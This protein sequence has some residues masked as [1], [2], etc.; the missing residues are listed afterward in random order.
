MVTQLGLSPTPPSSSRLVFVNGYHA[1]ARKNGIDIL[2]NHFRQS[3]NE[4]DWLGDGVYFWQD[5]PRRAWEW[6]LSGQKRQS[7]RTDEAAPV[8]DEPP[9]VIGARILLPLDNTLDLL[10]TKWHRELT[11]RYLA[12]LHSTLNA[13]CSPEDFDERFRQSGDLERPVPRRL[14]RLVINSLVEELTAQGR[15]VLAVRAPFPEGRRLY[16]DS[17]LRTRSH[18]QIA[19]RANALIDAPGPD[20]EKIGLWFEPE[21]AN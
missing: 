8:I 3:V 13:G 14:D 1:T 6:G 5:A 20:G 10:D 9:L 15:Q 17:A 2:Q 16:P 4:T 21:P 19:V 12:L 18:V 11:Q 7:D